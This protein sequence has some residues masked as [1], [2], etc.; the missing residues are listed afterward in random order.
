[1]GF[2]GVLGL[3]LNQFAQLLSSFG[4][5]LL[6]N[7]FVRILRISREGSTPH[8]S[9]EK[10]AL[11][12]THGRGTRRGALDAFRAGLIGGLWSSRRCGNTHGDR[13]VEARVL[14]FL[15]QVK[16]FVSGHIQ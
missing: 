7:A 12:P 6:T 14:T 11:V 13:V 10:P 8:G 2:L 3:N 4:M 9:S 16:L 15:V 1:M 5:L